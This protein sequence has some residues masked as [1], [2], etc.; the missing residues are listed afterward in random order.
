MSTHLLFVLLAAA[1]AAFAADCQSLAISE[2]GN[3]P[4]VIEAVKAAKEIGCR[5]IALTSPAA[6]PAFFSTGTTLN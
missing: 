5:S 1:P 6:V 4:N 2:S 3:S